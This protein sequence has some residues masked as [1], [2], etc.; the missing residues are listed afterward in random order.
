MELRAVHSLQ[1][2]AIRIQER[3]ETTELSDPEAIG[4]GRRRVAF[5]DQ[6]RA[7]RPYAFNENSVSN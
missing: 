5:A 1:D 2:S 7:I 6:N 4:I 3:L